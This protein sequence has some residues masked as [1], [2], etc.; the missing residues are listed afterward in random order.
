MVYTNTLIGRRKAIEEGWE[1]FVFDPNSEAD[2]ER[3]KQRLSTGEPAIAINAGHIAVFRPNQEDVESFDDLWTAQAGGTN[4][5]KISLSDGFGRSTNYDE[6][7]HHK[8]IR[9]FLHP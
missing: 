2:L 4:S 3:L 1:E 8:N 9:I 7:D 6:E 5:N